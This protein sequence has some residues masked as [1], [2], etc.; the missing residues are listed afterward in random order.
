MYT[1]E[2]ELLEVGI[3]EL[4]KIWNNK[5][6]YSILYSENLF[7][8]TPH[9]VINT[10]NLD[11]YDNILNDEDRYSKLLIMDSETI[12]TIEAMLIKKL[13]EINK[14]WTQRCYYYSNFEGFLKLYNISKYKHEQLLRLEKNSN[15]NY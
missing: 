5:K 4:Y 6:D 15:V 8:K 13:N 2:D 11:R 10:N 1:L 7:G 9:N 12:Y 3:N 14:I